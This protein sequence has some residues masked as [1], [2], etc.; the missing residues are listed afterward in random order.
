MSHKDNVSVIICTY[1]RAKFI[2][3][4]LTSLAKQTLGKDKFEIIIINN[5]SK[6]DTEEICQTF[7]DKQP[8][9]DITYFVEREQGL[10]F[11]RNRGL[12]IAKYEIITYIDDDA[13]AQPDFLEQIYSFFQENKDVVGIGGKVIPRYEIEEPKWMNVFLHGLVTKVDYGTSIRKFPKNRFP[14]GCNMSYKKNIL[15]QVG[16]FNNKLKWRADDKYINFKIRELTDEIY[17]IP[18]LVVQH[19]IDAKRTSDAGFMDVALKFGASESIR[20]KSEGLNTYYLKLLEFAYKWAG[21]FILLLGFYIRG[22]FTKG[23]Y[24]FWFRSL[25]TKAF[26]APDKYI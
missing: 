19:S 26:L 22:Q 12:K 21:S 14:V 4:A 13:Y 8:D 20:V 25:A 24:T 18:D 3:E 10:S 9:L 17:Y 16:G 2:G 15:E 11:A 5:N 23:N 1:N 7:I 6:D